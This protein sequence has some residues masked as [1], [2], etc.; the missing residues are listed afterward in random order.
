MATFILT[1]LILALALA[2]LG[3]GL[4]FGRKAPAGSCGGLACVP[5]AACF[6]CRKRKGSSR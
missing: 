4:F 2:G 1:F 6:G 5:G 3:L